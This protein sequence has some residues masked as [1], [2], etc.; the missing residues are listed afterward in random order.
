LKFILKEK[1]KEE[2]EAEMVS[3]INEAVSLGISLMDKYFNKLDGKEL[4]KDDEDK[5][6]GEEAE[7]LVIF[8]AKDPYQLRS[9]PYLIGTPS[10]LEDEFVGLKEVDEEEIEDEVQAEQ[11]E[12]K[13]ES[14]EDS[15]ALSDDSDE[16]KPAARAEPKKQEVMFNGG[17]DEEGNE[18]DDNDLFNDTNRKVRVE[19][20]GCFLINFNFFKYFYCIERQRWSV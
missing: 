15:D 5:D 7:D 16:E 20:W 8:E 10:Y 14:E 6:E 18:Q 4:N 13:D 9:L 12:E 3:K 11:N 1:T 2:K 19:C 17:D